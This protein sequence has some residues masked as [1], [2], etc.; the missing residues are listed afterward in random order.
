MK[1]LVQLTNMETGAVEDE[2]YMTWEEVTEANKELHTSSPVLR[3][4]LFVETDDELA[5]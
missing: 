1:Y 4:W 2:Q 3:S 5:L